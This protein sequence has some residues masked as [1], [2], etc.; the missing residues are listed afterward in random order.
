MTVTKLFRFELTIKVDIDVEEIKETD[1]GRYRYSKQLLNHLLKDPEAVR[2]FIIIHFLS[3]YINDSDDEISILVDTREKEDVYILRAAK[4]CP[5]E[6]QSFFNDLFA[7]GEVKK[8]EKKG[9]RGPN[10]GST[11]AIENEWLFDHLQSK[12]ANMV[13]VKADFSELPGEILYHD[14]DSLK[15]KERKRKIVTGV[16]AFTG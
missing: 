12:L 15:K 6:A 7:F 5:P 14:H 9:G 10:F 4:K 3:R 16:S 11:E 13:P 8:K 1:Y 2:A